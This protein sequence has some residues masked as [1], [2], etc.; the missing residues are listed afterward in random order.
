MSPLI[1]NSRKRNFSIVTERRSVIAWG[2][3]EIRKDGR[4]IINCVMDRLA[5]FIILMAAQLHINVK[6]YQIIHSVYVHFIAFQLYF[7]TFVLKILKRNT[8]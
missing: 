8:W 4:E 3:L 2:W 6:S 5:T 1:Q 7:H